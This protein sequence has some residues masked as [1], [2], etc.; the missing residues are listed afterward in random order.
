MRINQL[1]SKLKAGEVA[2]GTILWGTHGRGVIHTLAQAGMDFVWIC[3]EH[4]DYNLETV[5]NMVAHAHATGIAPIVRIPDLNY[6]WVTRLLDS[7][8]QSLILP[9][10]RTGDEVR[11]FIEFAKYHPEG[12]RGMAIYLGASTDYEDVAPVQA[13]AHANAN[14]L[15]AVLVETRE[16]IENLE[17]MLLPGI[18]LVLVGHQDLAQSF[19]IPGEYRHPTLRAA[20]DKVRQLCKERG[21]AVAG[22][23]ERPENMAS[24]IE[25]G[26]QFLLYGTDLILIRRE[27]ARAA[28]AL[29]SY[30]KNKVA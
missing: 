14:T 2:L 23:V 20:N 29:V 11:R 26:A 28:D 8:C 4:S 12:R 21:I 18:D 17:Q 6:E 25:G 19:G 15:L 3:M 5:T 1:R 22:A 9:H 27:A 30:R 10:A 13:M 7:G 16:A 24:V